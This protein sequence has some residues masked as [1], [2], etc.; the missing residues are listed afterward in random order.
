LCHARN[1]KKDCIV[2]ETDGTERLFIENQKLKVDISNMKTVEMQLAEK[3]KQLNDLKQKQERVEQL[4]QI[5]IDSGQLK[6]A[7]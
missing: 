5:L 6:P 2:N 3:D 7:S 1:K 4:I